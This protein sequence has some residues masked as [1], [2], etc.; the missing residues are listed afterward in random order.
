MRRLATTLAITRGRSFTEREDKLVRG[1]RHLPGVHLDR[2]ALHWETHVLLKN[3]PVMVNR[4]L[5]LCTQNVTV[6]KAGDTGVEQ[7]EAGEEVESRLKGALYI[8]YSEKHMFFYSWESVSKLWPA[9]VTAQQSDKQSRFPVHYH[10]IS[11][12]FSRCG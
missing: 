9:L 1:K 6:V 2:I 8:I 10:R 5:L 4:L 3:L 12:S 7:E 11:Y